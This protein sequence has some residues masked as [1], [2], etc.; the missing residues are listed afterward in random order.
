VTALD[1]ITQFLHTLAGADAQIIDT[2]ISRVVIGA[3]RAYK[4][5]KPVRFSYLD[6]STPEKRAAAAQRE[7]DLNR[8][9]APRLYLGVRRV[10]RR[11]DGALALDGAGE[12]IE[13]IVEMRSFDQADLFDALAQRGALTPEL[14]T[15]LTERIVAFHRDAAVRRDFGGATG[16]SRV[17]EIDESALMN[18]ELASR[19]RLSA[20]NAA[21]KTQLAAV[22]PLLDARRAAG[23]VRRCH[24]DLTLRNICLFEGEP[25]PFDCIEFDE[26]LGV[27]DVLYDLAFLLMDVVHRGLPHLASLAFNRYLDEADET[28]GLPALPLFMA[29][30]ATIRAHVTAAQAKTASDP[31]KS[32]AMWDEGRAYLALAERLLA[33]REK[34]LVAIGGFSGSGKST[35]AASLAPA[36]CAPPGARI[37]SSDRIR[38]RLYG[39]R[40]TD[41]LPREAYAPDISERVY[42]LAREE[43]ARTLAVGWTVVADAVFD[44]QPLASAIEQIAQAAQAPFAGFWLQGRRDDLARRI[45]G[46]TNDPSDATVAVL[47]SQIKRG[48]APRGWRT[49][50]AARAPADLSADVMSLMR[51]ESG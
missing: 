32:A 10:T 28:D 47:D 9:T 27:I 36:L 50:D 45:T 1:D 15:R 38:K 20:L 13:T 31:S 30:R 14:M 24:G 3:E 23:K 7:F 33:P 26:A 12:T 37:L 11:T 6:F 17:L 40:P 22:A 34:M 51:L 21:F 25:T 46:R 8:R 43:A 42:A 35:L 2:H 18:S 39:V 19:E 49:L 5:K 29:L 41:G 4:I 16:I 44:R 48:V